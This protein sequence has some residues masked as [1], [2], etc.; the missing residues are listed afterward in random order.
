MLCGENSSKT[1][2]K[3]RKKEHDNMC[4]PSS[5]CSWIF[6]RTLFHWK[7]KCVKR[8][9]KSV[10]MNSPQI[11]V[12]MTNWISIE[13]DDLCKKKKRKK[14]SLSALALQRKRLSNCYFLV[15][16]WKHNHATQKA[17]PRPT[18]V[19]GHNRSSF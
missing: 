17:W 18:L 1:K 5:T 3:K 2:E 10:T 6:L 14:K 7:I 8:E 15:K 9:G 13:W 11:Y 19:T 4:V 16:L 12:H